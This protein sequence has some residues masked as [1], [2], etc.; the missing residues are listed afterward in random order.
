MPFLLQEAL[1]E[2]VIGLSFLFIV[3]H[4]P[5]SLPAVCHL[6]M[7]L[8]LLEGETLQD[9]VFNLVLHVALSGLLCYCAYTGDAHQMM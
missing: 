3:S 6:C 8:L 7:T 2:V 1:Q 5:C 4:G 9:E